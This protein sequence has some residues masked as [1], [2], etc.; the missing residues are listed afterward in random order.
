MQHHITAD[1]GIAVWQYYQVTKNF[2]W[3]HDRGWPLLQATADFWASR[4]ERNG[5]GH[6]DIISA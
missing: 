5:K 6:Y 3:L 1:I 4:V 2:T